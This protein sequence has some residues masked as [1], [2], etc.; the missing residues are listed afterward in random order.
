MAP[1]ATVPPDFD[2]LLIT[3]DTLRA[4]HVGAYGYPRDTTPTLDA[5]AKEGALFVNGWAHAPSTRYSMPAI[6][7]GRWPSTVKWESRCPFV[8]GCGD[9][10]PPPISD[11]NRLLAEALKDH[12]Y[13]TAALLNYRFFT[14]AWGLGQGFTIYDNAR[15]Y[16]HQGASDPA[17]HGSS[18]REQADVAIDFLRA[19]QGETFFLWVHFYDPHYFYEAHP[20]VASFGSSNPDLYDGEIAFTDLHVGRL[21]DSLD[22]LGLR[23]RT[24]V[25]L[26]GD[27]GEGFGEHGIDF[28]GYH[29]Y[30]PQTKVPFIIRAPGAPPG[31]TREPVSH[32]DL[33]PTLLNLAGAAPE[34]TTLGRSAV[35]LIIHSAAPA[36]AP[37][38]GALQEVLYEPNVVRKA[39]ATAD[40]Q[41]IYNQEP[42]H[43]WELYHLSDD[44]NAT[45]DVSG[46]Q[47]AAMRELRPRLERWIDVTQQL[48]RSEAE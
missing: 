22:Q 30:P 38:R 24:V 17:T 44:P 19:H 25:A 6:M 21:L 8:G 14:P 4:D 36:G 45:R 47:G 18:S 48:M 35:D 15:E 34:P 43:T 28:H 42:D 12:G 27:H 11:D 1:P 41:L 33:M 46:A 31:R 32:V 26:T 2:V 16:L 23:E 40:W 3:I 20:E 39:L 29:L 7:A 37:P 13:L 10:W 9:A 5:I